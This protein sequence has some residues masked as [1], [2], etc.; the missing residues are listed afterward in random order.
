MSWRQIFD[1]IQKMKHNRRMKSLHIIEQEHYI[2]PQSAPSHEERVAAKMAKAV[3]P[4][5]S[6]LTM[7][8]LMT[9]A[10]TQGQIMGQHT[11]GDK[12]VA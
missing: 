9:V 8:S 5:A 7:Q 4:L 1:Q 3:A 6:N 12:D 11:N 10:A 2:P